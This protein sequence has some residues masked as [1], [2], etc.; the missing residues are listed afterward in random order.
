MF[1][2]LHEA[3]PRVQACHEPGVRRAPKLEQLHGRLPTMLGAVL[4]PLHELRLPPPQAPQLLPQLCTAH[5]EHRHHDAMRSSVTLCFT[6]SCC[7]TAQRKRAGAQRPPC[8]VSRLHGAKGEQH[9]KSDRAGP[10]AHCERPCLMQ[11]CRP[12]KSP[13]GACP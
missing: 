10:G 8:H 2:L 11:I 1:R 7:P 4:P 5:R 12:L 3:L 6:M 13:A 9:D